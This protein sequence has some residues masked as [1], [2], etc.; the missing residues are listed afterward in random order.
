MLIFLS[1]NLKING[2]NHIFLR[3]NTIGFVDFFTSSALNI[4]IEYKMPEKIST[5][6][7]DLYQKGIKISLGLE[8]ICHDRNIPPHMA[9]GIRISIPLFIYRSK[10]DK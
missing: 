8:K 3:K 9:N 4:N 1:G 6:M 5:G 7:I 10:S 2:I